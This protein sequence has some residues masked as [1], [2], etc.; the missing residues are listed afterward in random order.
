MLQE[1]Q[2]KALNLLSDWC[3]EVYENGLLVI[4]LDVLNYVLPLHI[5]GFIFRVL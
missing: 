1:K 2:S 5:K 3:S 4:G